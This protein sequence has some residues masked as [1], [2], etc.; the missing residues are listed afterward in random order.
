M[1]KEDPRA[2]SAY[3]IVDVIEGLSK[4]AG[5][6]PADWDL[7][8]KAEALVNKLVGPERE[9]EAR[10]STRH[11]V[12]DQR[13][14]EVLADSLAISVDQAHDFFIGEP[15]KRAEPVAAWA[16]EKAD[17]KILENGAVH[18]SRSRIVSEILEQWARDNKC[19]VYRERQP[20]EARRS[21]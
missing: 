4:A 2:I 18:G 12:V 14:C 5:S 6:F 17:E 3:E 7:M 10:W 20:S 8:D 11:I 16:L 15:L 1:A 13:Y 9:S 19:G 21:A